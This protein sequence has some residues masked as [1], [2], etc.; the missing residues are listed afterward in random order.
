MRI[1]VSD[2]QGSFTIHA[3]DG[4]IGLLDDMYF[5]DR[6]WIVRYLVADTGSWRASRFVLLLP[7]SVTSLNWDERL[8]HLSLTRW[9][10]EDSPDIDVRKPVSRQH[11][12]EYL[13]YYHWPYYW[14]S[15]GL[16]GAGYPP[17]SMMIE[18][19][20]KEAREREPK[21]QA[22]RQPGDSHLRSSKEVL[23]YHIEARDGG[24][25]HIDDF[26]IDDETWAIRQLVIDTS[27]WWFGRKVLISPR[28][29]RRVEWA[30][31]KVYVDLTRDEIRSRADFAGLAKHAA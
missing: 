3:T 27:N 1:R 5:D 10:V 4:D 26:I 11:E 12:M 13:D 25:G 7:G 14:S 22:T 16:W 29:I 28:K 31:A 18:S 8:I 15:A 2:I 21:A 23:G 17:S 24:I 9:Q 30:E 6:E 20:I 19:A